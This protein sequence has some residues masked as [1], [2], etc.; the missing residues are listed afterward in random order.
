MKTPNS[1]TPNSP[2]NPPGSQSGRVASRPPAGESRPSA[3]ALNR[4]PEQELL[5]AGPAFK[6]P[7]D[8][9]GDVL[10]RIAERVQIA[11]LVL[12]EVEQEVRRDWAGDRPYI[13]ANGEQMRAHTSARNA[14][15]FSEWRKGERIP[16]LA[17]R[18][19]VTE[20][21]IRQIIDTQ[22]ALLKAGK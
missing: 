12:I 22:Q 17:R 1:K 14:K 8:I 16:F 11:A 21:R 15:V 19:G 6:Q 4:T 7:D 18:H 3:F 20:R 5:L 10:A 2:P 9:I 13:A